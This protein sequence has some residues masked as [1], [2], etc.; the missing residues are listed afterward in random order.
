MAEFPEVGGSSL[1]ERMRDDDA[2][3][4]AGLKWSEQDD[5]GTDFFTQAKDKWSSFKNLLPNQGGARLEFAEPL[6]QDG[7]RIAQVD[8]EEIAVEASIWMASCGLYG[9][10]GQSPF[11][12]F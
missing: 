1:K 3:H 4:D 6:V 11:C 12:C 9:F 5:D 8:L 10:R 2:I 7:H